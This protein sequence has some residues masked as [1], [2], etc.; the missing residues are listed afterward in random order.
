MKAALAGGLAVIGV[1]IFLRNW[2]I[3]GLIALL[4]IMACVSHCQQ[5]RERK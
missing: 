5:K 3:V 1:S 4:M 2:A